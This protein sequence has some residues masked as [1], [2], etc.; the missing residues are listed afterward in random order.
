MDPEDL[1]LLSLN[2]QLYFIDRLVSFGY[3][4]GTVFFEKVTDSI[5]HIM[6]SVQ[7]C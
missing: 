2:H 3:R 7:L 6:T 5:R 4:H 1:D